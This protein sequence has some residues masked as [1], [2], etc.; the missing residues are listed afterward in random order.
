MC[1]MVAGPPKCTKVQQLDSSCCRRSWTTRSHETGGSMLQGAASAH[2]SL[3]SLTHP[4]ELPDTT[5]GLPL[6][7]NTGTQKHTTR[8]ADGRQHCVFSHL[9]CPK[10][11]R[12]PCHRGL[13]QSA[14]RVNG[15]ADP[16]PTAPSQTSGCPPYN[17]DN[18]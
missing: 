16:A 10:W 9:D 4:W 12:L 8:A 5:D 18:S 15:D 6:L 13:P 17:E 3:P 1:C 7:S 2:E 11:E 14:R